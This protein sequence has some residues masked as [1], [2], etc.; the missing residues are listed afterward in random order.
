MAAA[1]ARLES[2]PGVGRAKR[3][4]GEALGGLLSASF[5]SCLSQS[6]ALGPA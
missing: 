5:K 6:V 4:R 2:A 3:G 1:E